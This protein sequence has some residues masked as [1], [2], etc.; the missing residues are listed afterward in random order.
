MSAH[1]RRANS[2]GEAGASRGGSPATDEAPL[3]PSPLFRALRSAVTQP[4]DPGAMGLPL[5]C[6]WAGLCWLCCAAVDLLHRVVRRG[7]CGEPGQTSSDDGADRLVRRTAMRCHATCARA[8]MRVWKSVRLLVRCGEAL[9]PANILS[10]AK[11]A[12]R[13]TRRFRGSDEP[14]RSCHAVALVAQPTAGWGATALPR[15]RQRR[16]AVRST[17]AGCKRLYAR[18]H[19]RCGRALVRQHKR[20]RQHCTWPR[21]A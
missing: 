16:I 13:C 9:P 19:P 7:A 17:P 4:G 2:E 15:A 10:R 20:C 8:R 11:G 5:A 3:A 12:S 21:C 18:L 14:I 1:S 6:D